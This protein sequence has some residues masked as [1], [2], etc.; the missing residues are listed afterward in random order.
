MNTQ[1][2]MAA[3]TSI[4]A[5]REDAGKFLL[6]ASIALLVLL[7]GIN[8]LTSGPGFVIGALERAGLPGGIGYGVYVG[9]VLAPLLMLAGF[10]TRAAAGIVAFNMVV[11]IGLVHMSGLFA[12]AKQGG[13]WALELQGLYLAG[14]LAVA[15]LGAG[16]LSV[17]GA[18]GRFN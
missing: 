6:R 18:T 2:L 13:G 17:G 15:L 3:P 9:E 8:K 7:H 16:R 11:A 12:L 4:G 1:A 10:W 14:A 5:L